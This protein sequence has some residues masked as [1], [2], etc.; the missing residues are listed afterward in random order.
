[1][2]RMNTLYFVVF[3]AI[4]LTWQ[5][6]HFSPSA[7]RRKKNRFSPELFSPV[8]FFLDSNN[9]EDR[10]HFCRIGFSLTRPPH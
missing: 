6:F 5:Y 4:S 1:M 3:L 10:H 2:F 8:C 9:F 7:V